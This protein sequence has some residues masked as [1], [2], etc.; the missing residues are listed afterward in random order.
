MG[1]VGLKFRTIDR[2]RERPVIVDTREQ[3]NVLVGAKTRHDRLGQRFSD[4][5]T[6]QQLELM[7]GK[8]SVGIPSYWSSRIAST[9]ARDVMRLTDDT[10]NTPHVFLLNQTSAMVLIDLAGLPRILSR[11]AIAG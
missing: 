9:V 6:A 3:L 7:I 11:A 4:S 1:R 8:L 2:H 5:I 10:L